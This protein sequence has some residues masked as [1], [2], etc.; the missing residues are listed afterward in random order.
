MPSTALTA[1]DNNLIETMGE[2]VDKPLAYTYFN[3]PWGEPGPLE[4]EVGPDTWQIEVLQQIEE[5]L[6]APG[7][8]GVR[9]GVSSGNGAGKG[10]LAALII[11]WLCQRG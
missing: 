9:I 1:T 3:Y 4:R 2:L 8:E 11:G 5:A 6:H 10:T 7:D